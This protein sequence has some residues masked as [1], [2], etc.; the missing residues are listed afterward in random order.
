MPQ[1]FK[2]EKSQDNYHNYPFWS[3]YTIRDSKTN[4][5]VAIVGE[6]D[7]YFEKEYQSI[8]QLLA[9]APQLK[10]ALELIANSYIN[11]YTAQELKQI[12]RDA[13]KGL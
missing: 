6:I 12:A 1:N 13:L 11:A 5:C 10:R 9:S 2:V 4:V 8:A 7:R 3:T